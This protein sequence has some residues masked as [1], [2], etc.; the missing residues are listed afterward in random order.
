MLI[1]AV[2]RRV[3][4]QTVLGQLIPVTDTPKIT[5][6]I[7]KSNKSINNEATLIHTNKLTLHNHFVYEN[8]LS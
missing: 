1:A 3:S 6:S 2:F 5:V 8:S 7:L 4:I